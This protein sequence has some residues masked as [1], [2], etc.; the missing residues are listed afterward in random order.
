LEPNKIVGNPVPARILGVELRRIATRDM[1]DSASGVLPSSHTAKPYS[2]SIKFPLPP[3]DPFSRLPLDLPPVYPACAQST[4]WNSWPPV[5][6]C[7][8]ERRHRRR[9]ERSHARSR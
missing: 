4:P 6:A 2:Y 3:S 9:R 8:R 7:L 5:P 1:T